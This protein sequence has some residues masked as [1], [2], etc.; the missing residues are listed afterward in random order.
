[1]IDER[2][3]YLIRFDANDVS[4]LILPVASTVAE[5]ARTKKMQV[6]VSRL[7]MLWVLEV[8]VFAVSQRMTHEQFATLEFTTVVEQLCISLDETAQC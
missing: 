3:A 1:M 4:G 6:Y 2:T 7:P 5:L 8:V